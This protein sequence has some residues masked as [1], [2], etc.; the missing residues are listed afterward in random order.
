MKNEKKNLYAILFAITGIIFI[1][2][3][4]SIGL[5]PAAIMLGGVCAVMPVAV[6]LE[7]FGII[8][9][10]DKKTNTTEYNKQLRDAEYK[11]SKNILEQPYVKLKIT[12]KT[13]ED[14]LKHPSLYANCDVRIQMGKFYTDEEKEKY[15]DETLKRP[16]PGEEKSKTLIKIIKKHK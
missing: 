4:T 9:L 2:G 15:F 7:K 13:R 16:L 8:E 14:V 6:I 3:L 10:A 12:E 1:T 11:K 5:W